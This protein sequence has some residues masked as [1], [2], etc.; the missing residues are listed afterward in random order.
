MKHSYHAMMNDEYVCYFPDAADN[1]P[2]EH[3]RKLS[4]IFWLSMLT[5][6][7]FNG[8][9]KLGRTNKSEG[10]VPPILVRVNKIGLL[11]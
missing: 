9:Y 1:F 3:I 8:T 5:M 11:A 7:R 4:H 10:N 2:D 6:V